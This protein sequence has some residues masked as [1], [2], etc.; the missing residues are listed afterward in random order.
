MLA[1]E[2]LQRYF[3]FKYMPGSETL[4][5]GVLRLPPAHYLEYDIGRGA[6]R[7]VRYW[8]P[9]FNRRDESSYADAKEELRG[10]LR[11]ATQMRLI[12]DVPVGSFLSGGLD[13]SIIA[14]V[15][16]GN[17]RITHYC[18]TQSSSDTQEDKAISDWHYAQRLAGDWRLRLQ[19]VDVGT[20]NVTSEQISTTVKF[21]GDDLIA[22]AAQ[23]P[24]YLITRGAAATSKV[25]LSGMGAD[26]IFLR[27]TEAVGRPLR[28]HS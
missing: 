22:D 19:P 23:I 8:S 6:Q 1:L 14:G 16:R 26:E 13:S 9:D 4:F 21:G 12:A 5:R 28:G 18:A 3:V 7:L 25:F 10:L 2:N 20:G 24:T 17:D 27:S 15:L 11:D